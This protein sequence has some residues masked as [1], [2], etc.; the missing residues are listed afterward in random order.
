MI[1]IV[2]LDF[3]GIYLYIYAYIHL[4]LQGPICLEDLTEGQPVK[5]KRLRGYV[6][7]SLWVK[8]LIILRVFV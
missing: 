1:L 4:E 6:D 5:K 2:K 3:K 8:N 7:N